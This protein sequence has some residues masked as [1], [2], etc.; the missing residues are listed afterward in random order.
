MTEDSTHDLPSPVP[1]PP[2]LGQ[3]PQ[4]TL[5]EDDRSLTCGSRGFGLTDIEQAMKMRQKEMQFKIVGAIEQQDVGLLM[6][7]IH[8]GVNVDAVILYSKTP[9]TYALELGHSDIA[10]RLIRAGCDV[11]KAIES[12]MGLKAIHFAVL[13][14]CKNA[15]DELIAHGVD[16]N[17]T[18]SGKTTALHYACFFGLDALVSILLCNNADI[19]PRD[20]CG[21]TPLHRAVERDH[22]NIAENLIKHGASVNCQDVYGWPPLFHP[23]IF[24]SEK[25]VEF[26]IEN[27]CDLSISDRHGNTALHLAC[28]RCSPNSTQIILS[29][30]LEHQKR[31]KKIPTEE[32]TNLLISR[33]SKPSRAMIKILVN[34]GA[35]INI[36]NRAHETPMYVS[37]F[38][39]DFVLTEYLYLAGGIVD[40]QWLQLYDD[41][42]LL[43]RGSDVY[44]SRRHQLEPLLG[45]Q[46]SL[47]NQCR[48]CIRLVL[49]RTGDIQKAATELPIPP[50]LKEYVNAC[51]MMLETA[52]K[53]ESG[54]QSI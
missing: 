1:P 27:N 30:S 5:C 29:T 23:I 54:T 48:I 7:L 51:E 15:L 12:S 17:G 35:G 20:S 49:S 4:L 50:K 11:E 19:S 43:R 47:S 37:A 44:A 45:E 3:L 28:D 2:P 16:V 40:R 6:K 14:N 36:R 25:M 34:A 33:N 53:T 46:Y 13:R 39:R 41:V 42:L 52:I 22:K 24:N 38:S 10:C 21:R 18:D 8:G 9:L 32:L 31:K 26:L